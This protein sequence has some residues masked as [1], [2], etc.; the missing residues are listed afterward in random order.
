MNYLSPFSSHCLLSC[1]KTF[2]WK[3][4]WRKV[5]RR[6]QQERTSARVELGAGWCQGAFARSV[7]PLVEPAPELERVRI[8]GNPT[9]PL[10][11]CP[12]AHLLPLVSCDLPGV[13][14]QAFWS[15]L[16]QCQEDLGRN[17]VNVDN[18]DKQWIFQRADQLVICQ[19][20][21]VYI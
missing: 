13:W 7:E 3:K 10:V 21:C 5:R 4:R 14:H 18:I 6:Q 15:R 2:P 20:Y 19:P 17:F 12:P 11:T 1:P 9:A 8:L 16:R